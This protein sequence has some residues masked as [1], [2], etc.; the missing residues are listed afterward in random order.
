MDA[1]CQCQYCG[2]AYQSH[3]NLMTHQ[4]T[5]KRCLEKQGEYDDEHICED[6]DQRFHANSALMK[7]H[8]TC[9]S[10]A[11]RFVYEEKI[12]KLETDN[13]KLRVKLEV[14]TELLED[15]RCDRDELK[16]AIDY[17]IEHNETQNL[18]KSVKMLNKICS[19]H[20]FF[21]NKTHT[22]IE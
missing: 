14:K 15:A 9:K 19:R 7:H 18:E 1:E 16:F 22:A 3:I 20:L 11:A 6:C 21:I 17:F 5:S 12:A 2:N 10:R 13:R 4:K 8:K